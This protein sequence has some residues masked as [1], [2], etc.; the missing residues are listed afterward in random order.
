MQTHTDTHA[1]TQTHM[2]TH[3]YTE[4]DTDTHADTQTHM[5]THTEAHTDTLRHTHTFSF[6]SNKRTS[7]C[8]NM[9]RL[10][11]FLLALIFLEPPETHILA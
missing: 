4:A 11:C 7:V 10:L 8:V 6:P 3:R 1:D 5:Q 9:D 2:Q